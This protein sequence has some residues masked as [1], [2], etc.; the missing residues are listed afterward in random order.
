MLRAA[1]TATSTKK[2]KNEMKYVL[3][4][5][6]LSGN[7]PPVSIEFNSYRACYD[8]AQDLAASARIRAYDY[9][10]VIW[11]K[12]FHMPISTCAEKER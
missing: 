11:D 8:A 5:L 4:I 12:E 3:I 9:K 6:Y 1:I 7:T 10:G 2:G